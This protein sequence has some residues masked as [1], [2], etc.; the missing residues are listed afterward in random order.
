M[1]CGIRQD[2]QDKKATGSVFKYYTTQFRRFQF[3]AIFMGAG[4]VCNPCQYKGKRRELY[5]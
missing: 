3:F 5:F 4:R 1:M 2:K